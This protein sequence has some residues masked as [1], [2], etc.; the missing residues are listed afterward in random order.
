LGPTEQTIVKSVIKENKERG[1]SYYISLN[2]KELTK[3]FGLNSKGVINI[4][5]LRRYLH[6]VPELLDLCVQYFTQHEN[7]TYRRFSLAAQN[8]LTKYSWPGNLKQLIDMV[9]ALLVRT[10]KEIINIEEIEET[11]TLQGPKG[12]LLIES[13][14]MTLSMKEAKKQFET[15]FLTRQLDLVGG[16]ISEL[17]R[18]VEMERTNLYRK[19][20]SL[21]IEYKKK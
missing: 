9:H 12:N 8:M 7:L 19:L 10:D 16:K 20:Q 21:G 14:V 2:N 18:R 17:A 1:L 4:P 15:A 11:L 5:S 6:D 3:G 13:S